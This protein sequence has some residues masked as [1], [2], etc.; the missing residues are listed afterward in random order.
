MNLDALI[1]DLE[2]E[3][4]FAT[5]ERNEENQPEDYCKFVLIVRDKV[6]DVY[7]SIP[8]LG[9]DFVAGF[10]ATTSKSTWM[11]IPDY[12]FLT[13]QDAGTRFQKTK[14]TMKLI[15][16]SHLIGSAAKLSLAASESDYLGYIVGTSGNLIEFVTFDAKRMLIPIKS[17][18]SLLVEKL[19]M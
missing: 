5:N 11:V 4:Y 1:E 13:P 2:A 7:L 3:G 17:V 9:N 6:P 16:N 15:V 12:L 14:A 10:T 19:S 8:L 18:R